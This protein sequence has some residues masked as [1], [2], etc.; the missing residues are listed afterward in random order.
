MGFNTEDR[1]CVAIAVS[2][3]DDGVAPVLPENVGLIVAGGIVVVGSFATT[4]SRRLLTTTPISTTTSTTPTTTTPRRI[5]PWLPLAEPLDAASRRAAVVG[6]GV[7][8][9]DVGPT[10]VGATDKGA[11]DGVFVGCAV[12]CRVGEAVGA[13]GA[14]VGVA[15]GA[16]GAALVGARV[17]DAVGHTTKGHVLKYTSKLPHVFKYWLLLHS[18]SPSQKL[19]QLA[20]RQFGRRAADVMLAHCAGVAG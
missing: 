14:M 11:A 1:S 12:G 19:S 7:G 8:A 13:V 2:A 20:A 5:E 17:G 6:A 18:P 15:V 16:V 10:D 9:I 4:R 3:K